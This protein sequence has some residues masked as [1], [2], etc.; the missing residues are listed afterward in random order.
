MPNLKNLLKTATTSIL[1]LGV[2]SCNEPK[3]KINEYPIYKTGIFVNP[4]GTQRKIK[5]NVETIEGE[6]NSKLYLSDM[7]FEI[8]DIE[9][10]SIFYRFKVY[11]EDKNSLKKFIK[12]MEYGDTINFEF[13]T[14]KDKICNG[15]IKNKTDY[16]L[17]YEETFNWYMGE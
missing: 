14:N 6:N 16:N 5:R 9:D 10:S 7:I 15:K 4:Y 8:Q 2:L 13:G 12:N 17:A 1:A 11:N 3:C